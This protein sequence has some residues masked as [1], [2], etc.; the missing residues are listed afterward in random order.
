[1]I[2]SPIKNII[3]KKLHHNAYRCIDSEVTRKFYEDFL[4]LPLVKS[5]EIDV[6]KTGRKSKILHTFYSM[7]DNSFLAFFE[8]PDT[9]FPFKKQHDFDLHIALEVEKKDLYMFYKKAKKMGIEVRG[10][11][12]HRFI[13]S[14]YLRD[15]N[16][17]IIEL[18]SLKKERKVENKT[19]PHKIL[20]KWVLSKNQS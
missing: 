19:D 1:M 7:R 8:V 4:K 2:N 18:T 10:I 5:L 16:G 11:S 14:I 3:I 9:P 15:P 20:K 13:E 12:D 6:T 17:Y